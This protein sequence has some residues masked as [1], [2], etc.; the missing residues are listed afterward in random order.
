MK[1][2][3]LS[4]LF[5]ALV[6][7]AACT[8]ASVPPATIAPTAAPPTAT[9]EPAVEPTVTAVPTAEPTATEEPTPEPTATDEPTPEPPP[10][11]EPSPEPTATE[12]AT[13]GQ[14]ATIV[15]SDF[16]FLPENMTVRSGTRVSW[17]HLGRATHTV[18][19]DDGSFDSGSLSDGDTFD[20]TFSAAGTYTYY[21]KIHGGP[22][23]SG[24]SAIITV[25]D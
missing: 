20:F 9:G 13:G 25:T 21:C 7:L 11:D 16:S 14:N 15:I 18:T 23:Q 2:V 3:I 8:A 12:G 4:V 6:L 22:G 24:M 17:S 1:R 10:T 19:A 5:L